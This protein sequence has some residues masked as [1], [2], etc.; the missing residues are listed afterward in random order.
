[1]LKEAG[2]E[3]VLSVRAEMPIV[4]EEYWD[5]LCHVIGVQSR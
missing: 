2:G 4:S 1:M 5:R 3:V